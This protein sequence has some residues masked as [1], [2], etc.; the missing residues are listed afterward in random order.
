MHHK[1]KKNRAS[2]FCMWNTQS[3]PLDLVPRRH[4]ERLP[5]SGGHSERNA[6][7]PAGREGT[8]NKNKETLFAHVSRCGSAAEGHFV[9]VRDVVLSARRIV[10]EVH[11]D[12]I[13]MML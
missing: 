8:Y 10:V 3:V 12:A 6:V 13:K 2:R 5:G 7:L 11:V 1:R 4:C 9:V